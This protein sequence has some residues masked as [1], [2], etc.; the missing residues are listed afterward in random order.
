MDEWVA[1][2]VVVKQFI[3]E[4]NLHNH[5]TFNDISLDLTKHFY[6]FY[7]N[8]TLTHHHHTLQELYAVHIAF[9]F[10]LFYTVRKKN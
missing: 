2:I 9:H 3:F 5:G 4:N 1:Y 10:S 6:Y 8:I 7:S